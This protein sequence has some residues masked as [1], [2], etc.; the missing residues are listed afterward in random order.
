MTGSNGRFDFDIAFSGNPL[1]SDGSVPPLI[2]VLQEQLG[3][4]LESAKG[5]C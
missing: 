3:L 4:K 1:Q 5:P 2:T